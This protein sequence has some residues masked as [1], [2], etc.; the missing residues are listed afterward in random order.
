MKFLFYILY[1]ILNSS[2]QIID[3]IKTMLSKFLSFVKVNLNNIILAVI[4]MLL[5]L[6]SFASGYIIAKYQDREPIIIENPN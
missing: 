6:F 4:V 5:V 3:S 1:S 2:F